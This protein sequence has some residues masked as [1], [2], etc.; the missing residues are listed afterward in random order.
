MKKSPLLLLA[1]LALQAAA[2]E[3]H[4]HQHGLGQ[5]GIVVEGAQ[6]TLLLE[7]PQHDLVGF[8]RA[9]RSPR[10]QLAAQAALEK[11]RAPAQ[12]FV[13]T[14]AAQCALSEQKVTAPLLDGQGGSDG[15][16]DIEARYVYLCAN[17]LALDGLRVQVG[18]AFPR[19][20]ALEVSFAGPKGQKAG[21]VDI[22]QPVFSW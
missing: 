20:R 1:L 5:L 8:E 17:P 11:L 12:L 16:G 13:P 14:A 7:A 4:A 2:H 22:R 3:Q 6:L 19:L 15:H 9:A 21:R 18:E 10:E